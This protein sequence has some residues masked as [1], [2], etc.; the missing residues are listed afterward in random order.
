VA[1]ESAQTYILRVSE[2]KP[3]VVTRGPHDAAAV[4][5]RALKT[6]ERPFTVADASVASGLSLRETEAG[7]NA[8]TAEYRGHLRVTED[9]DLV[10]Y[11]PHG[12]SKPWLTKDRFDRVLSAVGRGLAGVGRFVVR[13]WILAVM[14]GY[15]ALFIALLLALSASR[16]DSNRSSGGAGALVGGLLRVLADALFWTFHPF[17]P[18]YVDPSFMTPARSGRRPRGA[19]GEEEADVPFYEKVNRFVFG[20][21][22]PP[23][24]PDAARAR[25]L[26]QIRVQK[27]RIGISDVLRVTGLPRVEVDAMMAK[28]MLDFDGEVDVAENGGIVYRFPALRRTADDAPAAAPPAAWASRAELPPL[29]GNGALA[30]VGIAL[31][32]GFNLLGASIATAAGLTLSN[33]MLL[34]SKHPP[35]VL[36]DDGIAWVLGVVPFVF[37]L[38]IFAL[39]IAR[40]ALRTFR[41]RAVTKENGR[42][43]ML[44]EI[45]E[46]A[47]QKRDV[48]DQELRTAYRV[49]T[50]TEPSSSEI[51]KSIVELGGDVVIEGEREART[52]SPDP[53]RYRFPGLEEDEA[54]LEEER[55]N[56][57]VQEARLGRVV[58]GSDR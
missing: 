50:G 56:A 36:P 1:L 49:A 37:S 31:L 43:A 28:L 7:L 24:D 21:A 13:A 25:V 55:E 29:T 54:A 19:R 41:A 20:P 44:K 58:F 8:L 27:G 34:F 35:A 22:L 6:P 42:R 47:K 40:A 32:N 17:S 48:D 45:L 30:N 18:V 57:P 26:A 14:V 53:I 23:P 16:S 33:A 4:L 3:Q 52:A 15:A 46:H 12:F 38:G 2:P 39:P 9:G 51:T 11:F 5:K 10:H